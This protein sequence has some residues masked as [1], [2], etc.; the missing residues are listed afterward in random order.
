MRCSL[1][2]CRHRM[3]IDGVAASKPSALSIFLPSSRQGSNQYLNQGCPRMAL[4]QMDDHGTGCWSSRL[5][6]HTPS[7]LGSL[8]Q[9]TTFGTRN[10]G[11]IKTKPHSSMTGVPF[12]FARLSFVSLDSWD[13]IWRSPICNQR[14]LWTLGFGLDVDVDNF[15][16]YSEEDMIS[17]SLLLP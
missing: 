11:K 15:Y 6:H 4:L 1:A 2:W 9:A 7:P 14:M 10:P 16:S 3:D 5:L 12:K 8:D 13:G 17:G